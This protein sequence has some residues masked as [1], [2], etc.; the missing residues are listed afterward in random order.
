MP[1]LHPDHSGRDRVTVAGG[2][3][4]ARR[5]DKVRGV[6]ISFVGRIVA[7]IIGALASVVLGIFILQQYQERQSR[8]KASASEPRAQAPVRAP[9]QQAIAVLPLD[10]FSPDPNDA[11]FAAG[12]TEVLISDL[13]QLKDWTVVSRTSTQVYRET[14]KSISQIAAELGAD[15]LVEGSVLKAGDRVRVVIQLIDGKSDAHLFARTYDR[16]VKDVLTLHAELAA[17]IAK[18][19]KAAIPA[20]HESRLNARAAFEPAVYDLYLRGRH[21]WNMRTPE[22]LARAVALFTEATRREPDFAL[23]HVGLADAHLMGGSS[24]AG[25]T[26]ARERYAQARASAERAIALA[27]HMAE[28]HTALGGVQFFGE[29]DYDAAERSFKRAI[30]LNPNY[31][32]AHE[33]YA[34][35]MSERGR[36]AEARKEID[37]ALKLDPMEAT[38]HQANGLVHYHARRFKEAI[39]AERRALEIRPQ[40]PLAQVLLLKAQVLDGDAPGAVGACAAARVIASADSELVAVCGIAAARAGDQRAAAFRR[41]LENMQPRPDTALLQLYAA[42]GELDRAWSTHQSLRGR[43]NLPPNL[44]FDP[45]FEELRNDPRYAGSAR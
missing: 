15:L 16:A 19:L 30:E 13:A 41:A 24:A 7:Q 42:T 28:A 2:K 25:S 34:V 5:K 29:R 43:N 21:A 17:E 37:A 11:Y 27:S 18:S 3:A 14:T 23:A 20:E 12:M 31:P 10:N 26:D 4:H 1:E 8:E 32:I 39:A 36:D 35:L 22:G 6:W 33:W 9:G 45:L 38:M 40:L 44:T